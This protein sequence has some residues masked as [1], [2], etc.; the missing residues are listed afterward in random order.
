[1]VPGWEVTD[2]MVSVFTALGP[3]EFT[4]ATV[5]FPDVNTAGSVTEMELVP[6]PSL[7]VEPAGTVQL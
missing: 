1:M 4:A 2:L 6:C 3:Q 5:T 7:I